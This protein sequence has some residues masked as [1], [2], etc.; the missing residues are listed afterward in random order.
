MFYIYLWGQAP[1]PLF[2]DLN[3]QVSSV[4]V[5]IEIQDGGRSIC[6]WLLRLL[7]SH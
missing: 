5:R 4:P 2:N 6:L 1:H 7:G 3:E